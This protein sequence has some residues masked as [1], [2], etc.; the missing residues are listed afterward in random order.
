LYCECFPCAVETGVE[1]GEESDRSEK[2]SGILK[3]NSGGRKE[4]S[5]AM[6]E[7]IGQW[8]ENGREEDA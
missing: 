7:T 8:Q 2:T 5:R 6:Q 1:T 4:D 3:E